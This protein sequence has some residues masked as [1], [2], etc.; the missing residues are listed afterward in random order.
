MKNIISTIYLILINRPKEML[1]ERI[2]S[3]KLD[4]RLA[5]YLQGGGLRA[6]EPIRQIAEEAGKEGSVLMGKVK[7]GK[8]AFGFNAVK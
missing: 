6:F 4:K 5:N 3:S 7:Q 8:G 2:P 1:D